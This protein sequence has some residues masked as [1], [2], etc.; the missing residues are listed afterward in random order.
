MGRREGQV[1][2]R[3]PKAWL[4]SVFTGRDVNGKR[5]YVTETVKGTKKR[6]RRSSVACSEKHT[7][8]KPHGRTSAP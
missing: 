6:R 2:K 7:R 4:V 8:G 3:G 1:R 5:Q